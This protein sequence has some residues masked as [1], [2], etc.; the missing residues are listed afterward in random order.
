MRG[1][2]YE[3]TSHRSETIKTILQT[4]HE[5]NPREEAHSKRVSMICRAMGEALGMGDDE[6][7]LLT[8]ISNLHDIGKIAI[9][10]RIL[11]KQGK[12]DEHEWDMIKKHPEIGYRI[13][14]ASSEYAEV[15]IDILSHH[16]YF[17]G[18]GYPRGLSGE[19]IPLR[20]RI[21]A[22]VDAFDAMISKRTYRESLTVDQAIQELI[23][24]KG[25]QF[26]PNLVDLFLSLPNI[27]RLK[28]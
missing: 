10:E 22:I 19:A 6:L 4:L 7:Q 13:L 23:N 20:A 2:S 27:R 16:E 18:N 15:A 11:N 24:G 28:P 26:D 25:T 12:L 21:I 17:D 1:S 8:T 3:T 14:S 9:D 5:K